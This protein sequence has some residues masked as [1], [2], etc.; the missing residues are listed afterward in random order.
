[1]SEEIK[2]QHIREAHE[3]LYKSHNIQVLKKGV[4]IDYNSPAI[5][6]A[7]IYKN[8]PFSALAIATLCKKFAEL[9]NIISSDGVVV[10]TLAGGP[11]SEILGIQKYRR[12]HNLKNSIRINVYDLVK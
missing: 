6:F 12:D 2:L 8:S 10:T 11:G 5:R 7:Y 4:N 3:H 9:R 1:M